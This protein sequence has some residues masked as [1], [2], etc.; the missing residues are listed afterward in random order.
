MLILKDAQLR[1]KILN[2]SIPAI[3]EMVLYMIVGVVDTAVVGRLGAVSLAAVGLAAEIFFAVV[4]L[5]VA[6]SIGVSVL[7]AQAWGA[8]NKEY[9][10]QVAGKAV[11][12]GLLLGLITAWFGLLYAEELLL[13]FPI[14]KIV[15]IKALAYLKVAFWFSPLAVI[16]YMVNSVFRGVGRTDLPM[17]IAII[18]NIINCIGDYLLVYGVLGFPELGVAGAAWATSIAHAIGFIISIYILFSGHC[19]LRVHIK[20]VFTGSFVILK[21]ILKLGTPGFIEDTI[22]R[23]ADIISIF[24]ITYLGTLAYASHEVALIVESVSFMPGIGIGIAA[25][26]MVGQA[27]GAGDRKAV[28]EASR[29]CLE[30][31]ILAMGFIGILFAAF[32]YFIISLFTSDPAIIST[33]GLLI[34]LAALEQVTI[35]AATVLQGVIKGS[36]DTRTPM[37][38]AAFFTWVFRLPALY[39]ITHVFLLP[40]AYIWGL[41]VIDWGLR[42]LVFA[43]LYKKR[44]WLKKALSN[45]LVSS[46]RE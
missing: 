2:I 5:M 15:Y 13:L 44:G 23:S 3:G 11:T 17:K 36:G 43:L 32:P 38:V 37:L 26:V 20:H 22:R 19:G 21:D 25:S 18:T 45:P 9:A 30:L 14:E 28:L 12:L 6:A 29:G 10:T 16:Y 31:G 8:Q 42:A 40:I 39:L 24:F 1:K 4:L 41:Y 27:I 7:T 33:A 46:S 34:R 35:A